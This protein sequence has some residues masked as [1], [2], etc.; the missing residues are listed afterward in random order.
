MRAVMVATVGTSMLL[1][2]FACDR[3]ASDD[4]IRISKKH[5]IE[6]VYVFKRLC[7]A[8]QLDVY[9]NDQP[10]TRWAGGET[11][12]L[13]VTQFVVDGKNTIRVTATRDTS[14]EYLSGTCEW[15]L[16]RAS[17]PRLEDWKTVCDVHDDPND[18][19]QRLEYEFEFDA[20]VPFRWAWQDATP[21]GELSAADRE[22]ILSLYKQWVTAHGPPLQKERMQEFFL[23]WGP[24]GR[25]PQSPYPVP[26]MDQFSADVDRVVKLPGFK[27]YATPVEELDWIVG[28]RLVLLRASKMVDGEYG[29]ERPDLLAGC[30]GDHGARPR[31]FNVVTPRLYFAKMNGRW[32]ALEFDWR[33]H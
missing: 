13:G 20:E 4:L 19:T 17:G 27:F 31:G 11:G 6:A 5:R 22:Q 24:D 2:L 18:D 25:A 8:W 12:G 16:D 30:I 3:G 29:P 33:W 23:S 26:D 21:I 14:F 9:I 28:D 15:Q 1:M 10:V 7:N 32:R